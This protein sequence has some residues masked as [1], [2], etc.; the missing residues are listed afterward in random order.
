[1]GAALFVLASLG[2]ITGAGLIAAGSKKIKPIIF[3]DEFYAGL[4]YFKLDYKNVYAIKKDSKKEI[5]YE[6]NST[7]NAEK[8]LNQVQLGFENWL[9]KNAVSQTSNDDSKVTFS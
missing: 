9:Q 8:Y 4:Q 2:I 7:S 6:G 5:V 1:M 3:P